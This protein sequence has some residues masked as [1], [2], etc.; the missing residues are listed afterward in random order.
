[1]IYL[2]ANLSPQRVFE[3]RLSPA[4][5]TPPAGG[6]SKKMAPTRKFYARAAVL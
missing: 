2:P 6:A 5:H 1:M 3:T 4:G